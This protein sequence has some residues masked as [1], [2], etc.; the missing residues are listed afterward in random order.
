MRHTQSNIN[1]NYVL[2]VWR[3]CLSPTPQFTF[4]CACARALFY[5]RFVH[6]YKKNYFYSIYVYVN[7][8]HVY[9][10][11][12]HFVYVLSQSIANVDP[13]LP[14]LLILLLLSLLYVCFVSTITGPSNERNRNI[15][16]SILVSNFKSSFFRL[17]KLIFK[18]NSLKQWNKKLA[19]E[20]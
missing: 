12:H 13:T 1:I 3:F 18:I 17:N 7:G 6:I 15:Y 9:V 8:M 2:R 20:W 10:F 4:V 5:S 11:C 19:F 16:H 14:I